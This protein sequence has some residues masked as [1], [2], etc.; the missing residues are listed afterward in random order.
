M[1]CHVLYYNMLCVAIAC[2]IRLK[3]AIQE[4]RIADQLMCDG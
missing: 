2:E 1:S 4:T 3:E